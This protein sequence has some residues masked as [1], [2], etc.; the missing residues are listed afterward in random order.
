MIRR[1]VRE[2]WKPLHVAFKH[3]DRDKTGK[4]GLQ[5]FTDI[6]ESFDII[7]S[8]DDFAERAK[9][10]MTGGGISYSKFLKPFGKGSNFD[11]QL[12]STIKGVTR[13]QAKQMIVEKLQGRIT[14][15]PAG[16]RRAF[17]FFD[18]DGNN[19]VSFSE[20]TQVVTENLGL[21][22]EPKIFAEIFAE[23]A[24]GKEEMDLYA[25][26]NHMMD[27]KRN[28]TTSFDTRSLRKSNKALGN[29]IS[30]MDGNSEVQIRRKV[31]ES[32][33]NLQFAFQHADRD[34]TG[35]I[36][37]ND[38]REVL[39]SFDIILADTQ[40]NALVA[41]LDSDGDGSISYEEF[42]GFFSTGQ[43]DETLEALVGI[44]KERD[45]SVEQAKVMIRGKIQARLKGGPSELRRTFQLFDADGGGTIDTDEFK[46]ALVQ[47]C[48]LQFEKKLIDKVMHDW[49]QGTGNITWERWNEFVMESKRNSSTSFGQ[50]MRTAMTTSNDSGNS[51]QFVVRKVRE[52]FKELVQDF[53]HTCD[54]Q[55]CVTPDQL[56]EVLFR[57]N[58]IMSDDGF[59]EMLRKIDTDGDGQIQYQEFTALF[60]PGRKE[61]KDKIATI[62]HMSVDAALQLIL[63]KVRG[64]LPGGP[65]EMRRSFQFFDRDGGGSIDLEELKVGLE[66]L[67]GLR[68]SD[69]INNGLMKIFS[70]G[71]EDGKGEMNY[72][73]FCKYVLGS[74]GESS[75]T[76]F[77]NDTSTRAEASDAKGNSAKMLRRKVREKWKP[78][79]VDFKHRDPQN[80]GLLPEQLQQVLYKHDIIFADKDFDVMCRKMDS[81]NDGTISYGEFLTY[82]APGQEDEKM[83]AAELKT[84]TAPKAIVM[85]RERV[86]SRLPPGP[87]GLRRAWREFD[88]KN[89]GK[90]SAREFRGIVRKVVGLN[91]DQPTMDAVWLRLD[92]SGS[93]EMKFDAFCSELMGSH[94]NAMT[95]MT[96]MSGKTAASNASGNTQQFLLRKVRAAWKSLIAAFKHETRA[97]GSMTP[98]QLRDV[99]FRH[100]IILADKQ[101]EQLVKDIDVD[102]DGTIDYSEFLGHFAVGSEADKNVSRVI[103]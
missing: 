10:A 100:D 80:T 54:K 23:F 34:G 77:V 58:I 55:G 1:K 18:R 37:P 21:A 98:A 71:R 85:I 42:F 64:R 86:E 38:L 90:V 70:G 76:S 27:S 51:L 67:C 36:R 84:L 74:S 60:A 3:A 61:D 57:F 30:A 4:L 65:S 88:R 11:K 52:R 28:S 15:G 72:L 43:K 19:G 66:K 102:G 62:T 91:F 2:H 50:H 59:K 83:T 41:K 48:G 79:I 63:E 9:G 39:E 24:G 35:I 95:S 17:K 68:F 20:F 69:K 78:L 25:F 87:G 47:T 97:T 22:L 8:P 101:F 46:T 32:W 5:K 81:D 29:R 16:L 49:S 7:F 99:L 13:K 82:F 96:D 6:L 73:Q 56:R 53:K 93:G 45:V 26:S 103:E 40:F 44:I 75:E 33:K 94:K 92:P 14:G 31:R 89:A 12:C